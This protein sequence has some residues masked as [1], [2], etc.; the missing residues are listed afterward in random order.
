MID[1]PNAFW[2]VI[3]IFIHINVDVCL[4]HLFEYLHLIHTNQTHV[5]G[6]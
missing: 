4:V 2:S 1:V 3:I 5:D 6:K